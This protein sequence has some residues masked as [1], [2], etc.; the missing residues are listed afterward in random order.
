MQVHPCHPSSCA[1]LGAD[2]CT[3]PV[4]APCPAD[5]TPPPHSSS[6]LGVLGSQAPSQGL[7][8]L[9]AQGVIWFSLLSAEKDGDT[10]SPAGDDQQVSQPPRP[11]PSA[12]GAACG[13]EK[14]GPPKS[15]LI[16]WLF[17]C[18]HAACVHPAGQLAPSSITTGPLC[19]AA[20]RLRPGICRHT[21]SVV[22][23]GAGSGLP[24]PASV[25]TAAALLP[26]A[27]LRRVRSMKTRRA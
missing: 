2:A 6:S 21:E 1:R 17:P 13:L 4:R 10:Q 19:H 9:F 25:L 27:P 24:A 26:R 22:E 3:V 15:P 20:A 18:L 23:A 7:F 14:V 5:I 16:R 11:V 12:A 8:L